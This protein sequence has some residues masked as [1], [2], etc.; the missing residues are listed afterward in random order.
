MRRLHT[1]TYTLVLSDTVCV[2][3]NGRH[4]RVHWSGMKVLGHKHWSMQAW[5]YMDIVYVMSMTWLSC[6]MKSIY[7]DQTV[8]TG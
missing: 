1:H 2:M 5:P 8:V 3:P 6:Y 7:L 4:V